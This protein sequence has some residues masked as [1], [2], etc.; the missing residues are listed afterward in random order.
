MPHMDKEAR[1]AYTRQYKAK[2]REQPEYREAERARERERYQANKEKTRKARLEK[3]AR[4]RESHREE[5]AEKERARQEALRKIDPET[6]ARK[7]RERAK[8]FRDENR[9]NPAYREAARRH[10]RE[11]YARVKEDA[12]FKAK[13]VARVKDW[14]VKNRERVNEGSRRRRAD[15]YKSDVQFK[16]ALSLRRRLYMAVKGMHRS[17]MAVRELGCSIPEFKAH[18]EAKFQDGMTWDNWSRGGWHIDHKKPL[19]K[20]DLTDPEQVK[21]A[22]HY[23]NLQPMWSLDNCSKGSRYVE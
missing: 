21:S 2:M 8:K 19:S 1:N 6:H 10:A 23:T 4:Y 7:L 15:R 13:N 11:S 14:M 17:G 20:F 12:A 9:D 18:I 22:C 16:I 3:N 5:L